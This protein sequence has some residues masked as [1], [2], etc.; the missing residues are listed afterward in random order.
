[1][2][3]G[4]LTFALDQLTRSVITGFGLL[5]D[6]ARTIFRDAMTLSYSLTLVLWLWEGRPAVHGPFLRMLLKFAAIAWLLDWFPQGSARLVQAAADTGVAIMPVKGFSLSD[7][8]QIA[9]LGLQVVQ[10]L[11][12]RLKSMLGPINFFLNFLEI[13]LYLLA[14][15]ITATAFC[16]LAIQVFLAFLEFHLLSLAA[17]LTIPFAVLGPTSFVAERSIGYIAASALKLLVLGVVITVCGATLLTIAFAADPT[18]AEAFGVAVLASA[19]LVLAL[20]APRA[21]AGL[22]NGGPVL[23]GITALA[24]LWTA[25]RLGVRAATTAGSLAVGGT[26]AFTAAVGAGRAGLRGSGLAGASVAGSAGANDQGGAARRYPGGPYRSAAGRRPAGEAAGWSRPMTEV[27][28]AELD[29]LG[30]G[31]SYDPGLSRG[32]ASRLIQ[33]WGG[34]TSW[35]GSPGGGANAGS[36]QPERGADEAPRPGDGRPASD[37]RQSGQG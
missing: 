23:D 9:F 28:R 36:S 27:Q 1:M 15:L 12:L 3:V 2:D 30:Q 18:L 20:K 37:H 5:G 13:I 8:G 25:G 33:D 32:A 35:Y 7:P 16:I 14:I 29:R 24:G 34:E 19:I 22:V 10:P 4:I 21:A 11:M 26:L 6:D 31:R 17:Y